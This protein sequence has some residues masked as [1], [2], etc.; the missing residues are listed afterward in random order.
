M[1][2]Q[3]KPQEP[4]KIGIPRS[5]RVFTSNIEDN[6]SFLTPTS[7]VPTDTPN[8]LFRMIR[9]YVNGA[10]KRLYVYDKINK[11][12]IRFNAA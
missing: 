10:D 4:N 1:E 6:L 11:A 7:S 5:D 2:E 8:N 9:L 3:I 12:W